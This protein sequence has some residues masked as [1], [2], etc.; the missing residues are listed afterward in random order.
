MNIKVLK[1]LKKY[2]IGSVITIK[3]DKLGTPLDRYWR[4]RLVESKRDSCIEIIKE[5]DE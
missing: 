5:V 1:P 3:T 4:N 2:V